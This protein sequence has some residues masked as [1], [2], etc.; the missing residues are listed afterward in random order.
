[1]NDAKSVEE[2]LWIIEKL[3]TDTTTE[4]ELTMKA[5]RHHAE[6]ALRKLGRISSLPYRDPVATNGGD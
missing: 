4:T 1:M 6:L 3:T 2:R 5:I